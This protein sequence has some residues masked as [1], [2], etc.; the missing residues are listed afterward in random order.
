MEREGDKMRTKVA[1]LAVTVIGAGF[2]SMVLAIAGVVKVAV[3]HA[4]DDMRNWEHWNDNDNRR[5]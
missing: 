1:A 2:L 3:T 4:G 5:R